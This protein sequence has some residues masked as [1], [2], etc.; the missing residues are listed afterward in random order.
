MLTQKSSY[1]PDPPV[2]ALLFVT[3]R[4][5]GWTAGPI[6]GGIPSFVPDTDFPA[7]KSNKGINFSH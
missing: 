3:G 7:M 4:G 2:P 1:A 5:V 6:M